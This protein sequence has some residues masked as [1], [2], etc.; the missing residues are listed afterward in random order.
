MTIILVLNPPWQLAYSDSFKLLAE[1]AKV[2][3][4]ASSGVYA[5]IR[6][7]PLEKLISKVVKNGEVKASRDDL[8]HRGISVDLLIEGIKIPRD[9]YG[10]F[11]DAC[12]EKKRI[13]IF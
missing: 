7:N 12:L 2:I 1:H 5:A 10:D 11:I 8:K 3:Y 4:L 13:V 9:F 6:G